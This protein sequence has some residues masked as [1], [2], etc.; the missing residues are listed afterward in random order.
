[1][2]T[3]RFVIVSPTGV[4]GVTWCRSAVAAAADEREACESRF[5]IEAF[6]AASSAEGFGGCLGACG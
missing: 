1:M 4:G 6:V 3:I 2:R 5:F